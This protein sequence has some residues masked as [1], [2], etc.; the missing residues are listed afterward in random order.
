[1]SLKSVKDPKPAYGFLAMDDKENNKPTPGFQSVPT[2][3]REWNLGQEIPEFC[4]PIVNGPD[5]PLDE[6]IKEF[7]LDDSANYEDNEPGPDELADKRI[8][9]RRRR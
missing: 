3:P 9:R 4:A 5:D 1:M 2:D 7:G 6:I 8:S